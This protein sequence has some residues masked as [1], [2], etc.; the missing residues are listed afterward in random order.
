M[1]QYE[2]LTTWCLDAP[3]EQVFDVLH[4]SPRRSVLPY[5]PGSAAV[6]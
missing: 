5:E 6:T 3:I 4:D 2:F 1:A